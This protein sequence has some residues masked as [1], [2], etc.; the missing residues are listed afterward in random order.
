MGFPR[1]QCKGQ[2]YEYDNFCTTSVRH[3]P[4]TLGS[5]L[6]IN[7]NRGITTLDVNR[8]YLVVRRAISLANP[9]KKMAIGQSIFTWHQRRAEAQQAAAASSS[10]PQETR[11]QACC[12]LS[13]A[14][15]RG[16][17]LHA[18]QTINTTV[19]QNQ[20]IDCE[21]YRL[22]KRTHGERH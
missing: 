6:C 8:K 1:W 17:W 21:E 20:S 7:R 18:Q 4:V 12:A 14:E 22:N 16:W 2:C 10:K 5:D 19:V 15:A 13:W 11:S 9:R 3:C